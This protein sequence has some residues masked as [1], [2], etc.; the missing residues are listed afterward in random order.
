VLLFFCALFIIVGGVESSGLLALIGKSIAHVSAD[1]ETLLITCLL[2]MWVAAVLSAI[3]DNIP[4]TVTMIPIVLSLDTQGMNV[5]PLWWALALGVGLGGNGSHIGA[6]ANIIC[7][8]ESERCGI[9]EAR[10]TPGLWLRKGLPIML[11]SLTVASLVFAY[12]FEY[13]M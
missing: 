7:V 12:F 4:F 8:A 1:P 3:V 9:P 10:I 11:V 5:T 6:T 13:F 2:L